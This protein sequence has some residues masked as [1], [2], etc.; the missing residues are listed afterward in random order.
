MSDMRNET[1][2]GGLDHLVLA[3]TELDRAAE[4]YAALGF[5]L[6]PRA[7]HP[8]GTANRLVQLHGSFL[9]VLEVAEPD[10]L[11]PHADG[12][13]SF[14]AYLADYLTRREGCAMLVLE[15]ADARAD[16]DR[17][18]VRGLPDLAPFDF[19]RQAALPDGSSVTVAFSL[20]FA[21]MAEA[22]E[23]VFFTC[24]QHAPE[25][26]W[27]PDYQ[28][29]ANTA[30]LLEEV[31]MVAPEP[32]AL[33]EPL[34]ALLSEDAVETAEDGLICETARGRIRVQPAAA[35]SD[36]Y[37]EAPAETASATPH[38]AAARIGVSDLGAAQA[39]LER[40]GIPF[41]WARAGLVVPAAA[42]HGTALAF[43]QL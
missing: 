7:L 32:A 20:A 41:H 38:F 8:W 39:V 10:R 19:E 28:V 34:Q 9:E 12:H 1:S 36:W 2:P 40:N 35:Y 31:A 15:S 6:T 16:R 18:A 13:F 4:R 25:H 14:G 3:V 30:Q 43:A 21:P 17:F 42:C 22:P 24:Q 5:A 11:V 37:G 33:R 26:F 29:H 27:K 23:A